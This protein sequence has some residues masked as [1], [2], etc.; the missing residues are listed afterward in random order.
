MSEGHNTFQFEYK[1][2]RTKPCKVQVEVILLILTNYYELMTAKELVRRITK[3]TA[4]C[5]A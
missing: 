1:Y 3:I 4:T 5:Y 2:H